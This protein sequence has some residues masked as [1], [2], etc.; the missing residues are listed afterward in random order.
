[1]K[2]L[3]STPFGTHVHMPRNFPRSHT[4]TAAFVHRR[5]QTSSLNVTAGDY[6]H[7]GRTPI[8][9]M[10]GLSEMDAYSHPE[11]SAAPR[12]RGL[13]SSSA[14]ASRS[15][16][17]RSNGIGGGGVSQSLLSVAMASGGE[18]PLLPSA[19]PPSRAGALSR[20]SGTRGSLSIPEPFGPAAVKQ[21]LQPM[22]QVGN[23]PFMGTG[24][25]SAAPKEELDA[26]R[27][28]PSDGVGVAMDTGGP[29]KI[30]GGRAQLMRR[31]RAQAS[32]SPDAPMMSLGGG[33]GEDGRQ[34]SFKAD[35]PVNLEDGVKLEEDR[36]ELMSKQQ[37]Q[38]SFVADAE[39]TL[40]QVSRAEPAV[41]RSMDVGGWLRMVVAV[42]HL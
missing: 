32:F 22:L 34:Q 27:S 18:E 38:Q 21:Q 30:E 37:V 40:D 29:G 31:A 12:R 14:P 19:P 36:R 16:A 15:D 35:A 20:A 28:G 24:G 41:G 2:L 25:F 23:M 4:I 6:S 7:R 5:G 33:E 13:P 1:M 17:S 26:G 10:I 9:N 11:P 42:Q 3:G 8:A 39:V